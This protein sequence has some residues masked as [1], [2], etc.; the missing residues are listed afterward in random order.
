MSRRLAQL[1]LSLYPLAFRRR[2]GEE[3]NALIEDTP[4]QMLAALDLLRAA[5][6]AHLRPTAVEG[7]LVDPSDRLRATASSQLAC[8]VA[9]AVAGFGFY[10]TTEDEP[11]AAAGH[12]H[13]L[14]G[15]A[16]LAVQALA[17]LASAAVVLG[18]LPLIL[19]AL[20]RARAEPRLRRLV[21]LPPLV[22][23]VFAGLTRVL[24]LLAHPEP[25][26][27]TSTV[28]GIA[29]ISW[30]V[31]GLACGAVCVVAARAALFAVAV[32]RWRLVAAYACGALVTVA[33][34][35]IT[36]AAMLYAIALFADASS[37]AASGNGPFQLVSVGVSLIV[38]LLVMVLT[39]TLAA[40]ST[41]RGWRAVALD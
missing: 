29:F 3:L 38:Q 17:V 8:W 5:I 14:L 7:G 21:S 10:K 32:P 40:T 18:A 1:A 28:G 6:V 11:F 23:L 4:P 41:Q 30:G 20:A 35:A 27:H 16:Y 26:S 33:M 36:L 22:V 2:Y 24:M 13:H 12:A 37:L 19:A 34:A 31:A 15:G 9:F 25:A 39:A